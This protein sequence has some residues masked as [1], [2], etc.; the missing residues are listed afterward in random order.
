VINEFLKGSTST[1]TGN[2]ATDVGSKPTA[3]QYYTW[4]ATELAGQ[5]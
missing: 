2:F 5:L 4:D 3:T 1:Q